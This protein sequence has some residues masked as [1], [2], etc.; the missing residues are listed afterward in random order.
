M[1]RSVGSEIHIGGCMETN[2][3]IVTNFGCKTNCWYCIWK[4]HRLKNVCLDTD[5]EKLEKFLT[6]NKHKGKVSVSG[7]GD[8]LYKY[9][10]YKD[11]WNRLF[12]ITDKLKMLVD[13]HSREKFYDDAFWSGINR[14]VV[15]SDK[16]CDDLEYLEYLVGRTKVR[17]THLVTADTTFQMIDEYLDFQKRHGTQFTIK[18]L[19]GYD[20][21]GMYERVRERYGFV[22]HLD[23]G[24]YNLYYMPDN[25]IT[26]KF[27]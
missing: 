27:L 25:S 11:W 26:D 20:D 12:E 24:D 14:A 10:E 13:V 7:G 2:I 9:D 21:N 6:D 8:C 18:K 19:V 4:E 17:V 16:L 3:S 15:S 23:P 1:L 22:F 5:W